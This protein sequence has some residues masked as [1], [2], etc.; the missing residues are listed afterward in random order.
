MEAAVSVMVAALLVTATVGWHG[1]LLVVLWNA[2]R[3]E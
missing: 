3:G 2:T 1:M